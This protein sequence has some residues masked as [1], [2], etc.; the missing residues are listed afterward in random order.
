MPSTKCEGIRYPTHFLK[1]KGGVIRNRFLEYRTKEATV[2][3]RRIDL[4][5]LFATN[6]AKHIPNRHFACSCSD[7]TILY[8]LKI[9][10]SLLFYIII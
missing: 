1:S 3:A 10:Q 4:Y 7:F 2:F 6:R 5:A 9:V 8:Q